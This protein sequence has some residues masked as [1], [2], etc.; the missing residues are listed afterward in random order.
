MS[1]CLLGEEILFTDQPILSGCHPQHLYLGYIGATSLHAS[2]NGTCYDVSFYIGY[3]KTPIFN[4]SRLAELFLFLAGG[5]YQPMAYKIGI[6]VVCLLV[7]WLLVLAGR[8]MGL[9][10]PTAVLGTAAG[11]ILWWSPF[12]QDA[13]REGASELLLGSLAVLAHTGFLVRF[14]RH[15]GLISWIGLVF[16]AWLAWFAQPMLFPIFVVLFLVYYVNVG[17]SHDLFFWHVALLL[18]EIL[19]LA[20]T[21]TWM[22]DWVTFWWLRAPLPTHSGVLPHRTVQTIWN[23]SLWGGPTA[24]GLVLFL[25]GSALIGLILLPRSK[26]TSARILA[27][28]QIGLFL[29]ALLGISWEPLG[30]LGTTGLLAPA[31]WFACLPAANA[32][33]ETYC[34]LGR[35]L[36]GNWWAGLV[37]AV[38]GGAAACFTWDRIEPFARQLRRAESLEFTMGPQREALI[39]D[40]K[41]YTQAEGRILWEEMP[42]PST[43]PHWTPLLP[44][45]TQRSFVGGLDYEAT[46]EHATIGIS[47][48]ILQGE[49]IESWRDARLEEYCKRYNIG[50]AI[51]FSPTAIARLSAWPMAERSVSLADGDRPG[52]LFTI[53]RPLSYTLKGQAELREANCRQI[54]LAHVIPENGVVVLSLHY[55]AGMR[56]SPSRVRVEV[57][58][59]DT[60]PIGFLRLRLTGPAD[61]VTLSWSER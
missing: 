14:H 11:L 46:I 58:P 8:G 38:L 19:S 17:H 59:S 30:S 26:R 33:V 53:K 35:L 49:P 41:K 52:V 6:A 50:W 1:W 42:R 43:A 5:S 27:A 36:G 61:R 56:A 45:L 21:A 13:L 44:I 40:I 10:W 47:N 12:S 3:P 23:A 16:T 25:L 39:E 7:P 15:P 29:L 31:L 57:E 20:L 60:D 54:T 28:G 22:I 48:G 2:G 34:L 55:Q 9:S 37:V 24:R 32:W 18:G 51:C 4:G